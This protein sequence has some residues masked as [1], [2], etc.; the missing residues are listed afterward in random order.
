MMKNNK[1]NYLKKIICDLLAG[2]LIILSC[3]SLI[4]CDESVDVNVY[5]V[6][7][8]NSTKDDLMSR[9]YTM[10]NTDG[11]IYDRIDD[12]INQMF[13]KNY[14][15]DDFYSAKPENVT[16]NSY[17]VED[18]ILTF[19]FNNAYLEMTNVQELL[20]RAAIVMSIIQLDGVDG[21]RINVNGEPITYSDGNVIGTMNADDF[22]NILLTETGMLKQ[23]TDV[24]LYFAN[25]N[26]DSLIPVRSHFI[27]SG[28]NSSIEEYILNMIIAGPEDGSGA[29]PTISPDVEL[30]SVISSDDICYVNFTESFLEQEPQPVSDELL[31]YSIVNS[32]CRLTFIKSVQFLING[33]IASTLH[34]ITDLSKPFTRNRNLEISQTNLSAI[35]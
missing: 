24:I 26:G 18:S 35:Y 17:V 31:I 11:T 16:I 25:E 19:D 28:N 32:L 30:I 23:E 8:I 4:A 12:I 27:T 6:Y 34:T 20:L 1:K 10:Q 2:M 14:T 13:G 7:Y 21:I 3:I 15:D 33:E 5:E 29:Y 22:V 9:D